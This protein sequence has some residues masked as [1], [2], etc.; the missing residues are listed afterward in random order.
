MKYFK[1]DEKTI[2]F[3]T[4]KIIEAYNSGFVLTRIGKGF[5]IQTRSLRVNLNNFELNSENRRILRK[6][7]GL[8]SKLINLPYTDYSWEIHKL[9]KDYYTRKFGEGIMT[10]NKIKSMFNDI[11]NENMTHAFKYTYKSEVVGYTLIYMNEQIMHYAYPFYNLDY[12]TYNLGM[13][14]MLRAITY[15]KENNFQYIYLGSVVEPESKYKLQFEGLEWWD[16]N[17]W[18]ND[19]NKL[20]ELLS[21]S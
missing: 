20:K 7:D 14:M 4:D 18:S 11:E 9:G 8:E 2:D 10:A 15:A 5:V 16:E 6:T 1:T 19:I 21:K 12:E 3:K 17:K 13:G